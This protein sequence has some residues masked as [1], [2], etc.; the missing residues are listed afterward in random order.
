MHGDQKIA[1]GCVINE[2]RIK[3]CK[4][5]RES[6]CFLSLQKNTIPNFQSVQFCHARAPM[7][8]QKYLSGTGLNEGAKRS[9]MGPKV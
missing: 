8:S 9:L 2:I 5:V 1:K 4:F 7:L 6:E 3:G